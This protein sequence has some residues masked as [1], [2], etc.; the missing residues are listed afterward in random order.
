L[1]SR[2]GRLD[3]IIV[4]HRDILAAIASGDADRAFKSAQDHTTRARDHMLDNI[5]EAAGKIA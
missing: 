5:K 2:P 3:E 1:G 4:E